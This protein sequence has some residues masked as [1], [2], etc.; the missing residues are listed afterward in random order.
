MSANL[1]ID[2]AL[3]RK[4]GG[5]GPRYTSYPT[6]DRFIEA[7]DA[8]TYR[9]WL[10][11]RRG[12]AGGISRPLALYVHHPFC[13]TSCYFCS[14]HRIVTRDRERANVYLDY[15]GRE[16]RQVA[17]QLGGDRVLR[18]MHWGGGTPTFMGIDK[19]G[20]LMKVVREEFVLAPGG[21]FS[22]E[23]DPR[24]VT[25]DALAQLGELG[26]N[27]ASFGVQDFNP[28][29][30]RVINRTQSYEQTLAVMAAARASGFKSVRVDL[31]YGLPRQDVE[32]FSRTLA[33]VIQADPDRIAL[34]SYTHMPTLIKP[35]RRIVEA[36][37]PSLEVKLQLLTSAIQQL[38][39]A[40]YVYI[41]MDHFARL[42]DELAVAQRQGSLQRDFQGYSSADCDTLGVGVSAIGSIGP[43]YSQNVKS[44]EAYFDRLDRDML[45]V[46]CGIELTPDDLVR[47]AVIRALACHFVVSKESI[48]IAYLLDFDNYFSAE[49]AD[50]RALEDDGLVEVD[51]EWIT[52]TPR[53]R[54]LVRSVC[55]VFDRYLRNAE[56][57]AHYSMIV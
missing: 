55:M 23:I 49:L 45:P 10:E 8:T 17:A 46:M 14:C 6:A 31:I 35:Q 42:D 2:P 52:V 50:L 38:Q 19:L 1:V 53:G 51:D 27:R 25:G 43:V 40:G 34:Y 44:L 28:E 30:Q 4:Y 37:L 20:A 26:F 16:I 48:S 32:G 36:D 9:Y 54:L 56:Q 57:R 22:I 13:D 21:V 11:H 33:Q 5:R 39:A 7:F 12:S 15:L 41:G 47:R 18:Q 29:V 3:I 24:T